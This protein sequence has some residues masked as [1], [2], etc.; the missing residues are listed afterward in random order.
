[1]KIIF[2]FVDF[3][4]YK[5]EDLEYIV[6]MAA[7]SNFFAQK[8]GYST[9]LFVDEKSEKLFKN[10]KYDNIQIFDQKIVQHL[11][12]YIWSSGK[13]LASTMINEPFIHIDFDLFLIENNL[14]QNKDFFC[15]FSEPFVVINKK[16]LFEISR[17]LD[18]KNSVNRFLSLNCAVMGGKSVEIIKNTGT[19]IIEFILANKNLLD[20]YNV[21]S[22]SSWMLAVIFEQM[23]FTN[24]IFKNLKSS[25][26]ENLLIQEN[27][28]D[29]KNLEN[30]LLKLGINH[31]WD[32]RKYKLDSISY[33]NNLLESYYIK[34]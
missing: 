20:N 21:L 33:V 12:K 5:K 6:K 31:L 4:F 7:L 15:A 24:L 32:K 27:Y 34:Y 1:M 13:I 16:I 22:N 17:K 9:C 2:S 25:Y 26:S 18:K 14:F 19:E 11:P 29:V 23:F 10:I 3:N 8:H 28:K 30:N